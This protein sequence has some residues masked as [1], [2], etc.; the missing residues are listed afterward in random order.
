[1]PRFPGRF[2]CAGVSG[3]LIRRSR[4]GRPLRLLFVA[5]FLAGN[6]AADGDRSDELLA[7]VHTQDRAVETVGFRLATANAA[8]CP[9]AWNEGFSVHTL[10]Q[11]GPDYRANATKLFGLGTGVGILAVAAGS[12]AAAAGLREGDVL[13]RIDGMTLPAAQ[14]HPAASDFTR[15]AAAQ[16]LIARAF[17]DGAA[18]LVLDRK[19]TEQEVAVRATPACKSIF[20]T[21]PETSV[22]GEADGLYVQVSTELVA[23]AQSND[24][25]AALL[26]HELAHN[27]LGHRQVLDRLHVDRGLLAPVGRNARLIRETEA[28][29]DRLSIH[30]MARAGFAPN[31]AITFWERVREATR[32]SPG[33][34]THPRWVARLQSMRIECDRIASSP[35]HA[36]LPPDL[37]AKLP[38][39]PAPD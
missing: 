35:D 28:E 29:A 7:L 2:N 37:L 13:V 33:S 20:Q 6:A 22:N 21:V 9:P 4:A 36:A 17:A 16:Q 30:L 38:K 19:R 14:K 26:A 8:L 15:T 32:G 24:E 3:S 12:P 39:T 18:S 34:T 27:V 5:A 25:L 1:M 23:L 31:A 11:Y 10:E